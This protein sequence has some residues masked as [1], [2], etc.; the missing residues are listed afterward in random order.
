MAAFVKMTRQERRQVARSIMLQKVGNNPKAMKAYGE[1]IVRLDNERMSEEMV[2]VGDGGHDEAERRSRTV[3]NEDGSGESVL[4]KLNRIV[5]GTTARWKRHFV[6]ERE[7]EGEAEA[8]TSDDD[9]QRYMS[10]LLNCTR[11]NT[12]Q[13]TR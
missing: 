13:E 9:K 4:V 7:G 6:V 12:Q 5:G 3:E 2:V 11:R 1:H 8:Q 10:R